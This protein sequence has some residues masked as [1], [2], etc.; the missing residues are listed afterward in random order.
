ML[1]TRLRCSV[2]PSLSVL[3]A[4]FLFDVDSQRELKAWLAFLP[5]FVLPFFL[6]DALEVAFEIC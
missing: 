4:F 6:F 3:S 2:S 5:V 1:M